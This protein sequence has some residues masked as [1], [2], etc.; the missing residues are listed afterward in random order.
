[1]KHE[2]DLSNYSIRTDLTIETIDTKK[3]IKGIKCKSKL[4]NNIKVT[5]VLVHKDGSKLINKKVGKYITIEFD[6]VTDEVNK[7]EIV[8]VFVRELKKLIKIKDKSEHV[9]IIGLGNS[10]STPDSLGPLT[11]DKITVTNHLYLL[12]S[13]D[14]KYQ[15]I[16]VFNPGVMGHTGLE[17]S[18]LIKSVVNMI[19]PSLVIV[20]DALAS[21]SI[22]RVNK[23]IQ[24][25]TSG[26]HPG[27]GIGNKRKEISM[28][29]LNVPVIAI[30]VPTVVDA[31]SIVSDTINYMFKHYS[32]SKENINNPIY[33][34]VPT[35][36]NY[37][38]K[39]ISPT[40]EDK[41]TL[42]GLVGSLSEEEIRNLIKEV[43]TPIGYNLM[44]TPK[45]VDFTI[46]ELSKVI[47][48]GIN[49]TFHDK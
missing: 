40:K 2:V 33:K 6:D 44:V 41:T 13:L 17:T 10:T 46:E 24:M 22:E 49:Q 23:T 20:I 43:L 36:I 37:L 3:K 47:S 45:E 1:M 30:G 18:D 29:T 38:E 34:L 31:V 32:F 27:S 15:R 25:T 42:L 48:L 12:N 7:K 8:K 14:T 28:E 5:Y 9:L 16:S 39:D 26:I 11:I 35:G 21:Q 19:E 4:F